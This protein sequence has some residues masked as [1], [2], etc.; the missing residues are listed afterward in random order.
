MQRSYKPGQ[1]V[2][3]TGL[4]LTMTT[5]FRVHPCIIRKQRARN[6]RTQQGLRWAR[7]EDGCQKDEGSACSPHSSRRPALLR[8]ASFLRLEPRSSTLGNTMTSLSAFS[9]ALTGCFRKCVWYMVTICS[10]TGRPRSRVDLGYRQNSVC[11]G[12]PRGRGGIYG[13]MNASDP[14]QGFPSW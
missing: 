2:R 10:A 14:P 5:E 11:P 13:H 8:P 7:A 6:K 3:A 1:K 9:G 12:Q 4:L